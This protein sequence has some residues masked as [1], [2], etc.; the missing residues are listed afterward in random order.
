MYDCH[1][2]TRFSTDGLM[3]GRSMQNSNKAGS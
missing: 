2:H 1:M 3:D